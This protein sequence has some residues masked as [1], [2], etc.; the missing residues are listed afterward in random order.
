MRHLCL[1]A[2][3]VLLFVACHHKD[4]PQEAASAPVT[5]TKA[6][7]D[8]TV[9][10][11]DT[12]GL[13]TARKVVALQQDSAEITNLRL[14]T[15]KQRVIYSP[16]ALVSEWLMGTMHMLYRPDGTG[17]TW[18][19]ADDVSREEAQRFLWSLD[20]NLLSLDFQMEMGAV[21][22]KLFVVTFVD[23]ESLAY[24]NVFDISFLWDKVSEESR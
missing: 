9:V 10:P 17:L 6:V 1:L 18:N 8:T 5:A 4:R 19:T 23:E 7:A 16:T 15:R 24:K 11:S 20:S 3:T 12:V 14:F 13:P 21:V 2:I 22:P